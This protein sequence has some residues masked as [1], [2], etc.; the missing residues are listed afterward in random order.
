[1]SEP[2][3]MNLLFS[4]YCQNCG[5]SPVW[6]VM[7]EWFERYCPKCVIALSYSYNEARDKI[8]KVDPHKTFRTDH[9]LMSLSGVYRNAKGVYQLHDGTSFLFRFHKTHVDTFIQDLDQLVKPVTDEARAQVIEK[10]KAYISDQLPYVNA[11]IDW[12]RE[13]QRERAA[14][15]EAKRCAHFPEIFKRLNEAEWGQEVD[16]LQRNRSDLRK[17][18]ELQVVRQPSKLRPK[19][20]E[21]VFKAIYP[22]LWPYR[23]RRLVQECTAVFRPRFAALQAAIL[24][25]YIQLPRTAQMDYH[26][27]SADLALMDECRAI[28]DVPVD[29]TVAQE[30]F[31]RIVPQLA[32]RW[33]QE[34]KKELTEAVI[35]HLSAPP[36]DDVDVLGLGIALF[37]CRV[38][39]FYRSRPRGTVFYRYPAVLGHPCAHHPGY[40][41]EKT[42]NKDM[43]VYLTL[44]VMHPTEEREDNERWYPFSLSQFDI[45]TSTHYLRNIMETMG[46]DPSRTTTEE[47]QACSA[48]L[49]CTWCESDTTGSAACKPGSSTGMV[50]VYSWEAALK[51]SFSVRHSGSCWRPR[52]AQW[53][54]AN[55]PCAADGEPVLSLMTVGAVWAC[56]LCVQWD[57]DGDK[58]QA[59]LMEKHGI[60]YSDDCIKNGTI[61]LHQAKSAVCMHPPVSVRVEIDVQE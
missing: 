8:L 45:R 19:S 42:H 44:A 30:D 39:R 5:R 47:L 32:A 33:E 56:S 14:R 31:A 26:P 21:K 2:A 58:V 24:A 60:E 51:H 52:P 4:T 15:V 43:E 6:S 20:W 55:T 16:S 35:A 23:H 1:M 46:L 61:Y 7:W 18:E 11:C 48:R 27:E 38:C 41:S 54:L 29:Q 40:D 28:A 17:M 13:L 57:D 37:A 25:H 53:A 59:H 22:I 50:N 12:H 10:Q 36:P 3:F 34:R 9:A 49:R